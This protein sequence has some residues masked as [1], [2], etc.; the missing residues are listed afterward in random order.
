[1]PFEWKKLSSLPEISGEP[2]LNNAWTVWESRSCR[3]LI[4]HQGKR[5]GSSQI[6]VQRLQYIKQNLNGGEKYGN[7]G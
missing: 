2:V 6:W 3:N 7:A 1:M 4:S 5:A